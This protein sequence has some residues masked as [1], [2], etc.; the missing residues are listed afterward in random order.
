MSLLTRMFLVYMVVVL[1]VMVLGVGTFSYVS[2]GIEQNLRGNLAST[3]TRSS[4]LLDNLIKPMEYTSLHLLS[5]PRFFQAMEDL[6]SIERKGAANMVL[7]TL[8]QNE[9]YSQMMS[10]SYKKYF[11][12]ISAFNL[13]GDFFTSYYDFP[14]PGGSYKDA[15][16]DLPWLDTLREHDGR[17]VVLPPYWDPWNHEGLQRVF[18]V[19][20]A[21]RFAPDMGYIEVQQPYEELERVF[22][23]V[24]DPSQGISVCAF[25]REGGVLY[26]SGQSDELL[27]YYTSLQTSHTEPRQARNPLTGANEIFVNT[28]SEQT[29][30]TVLLVQDY[31]LLRQP[32]T[33]LGQQML[34][35]YLVLVGV[36]CAFFA[37]QSRNLVMPI[38]HLKSEMEATVL[39]SLPKGTRFESTNN[40]VT[41]L[42]HAFDDLKERLNELIRRELDLQNLQMQASFDALQAQVNP[43]FLYNILG[44]ISNRAAMMGDEETCRICGAIAGMLRYS[45]NTKTRLVTLKDEIEHLN[46]Y[47]YLMKERYEHRLEYTIEIDPAIL[48]AKLPKMVLQPLAENTL[49][50]AFEDREGLMRVSVTGTREKGQWRLVIEDNGS[51]FSREALDEIQRKMRAFD[52]D[53]ESMVRSG[54]ELGGLGIPNI[55]ARLR[56]F[57]PDAF[58]FAVENRK[59]GGARVVLGGSLNG[60]EDGA[61]TS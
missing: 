56:L 54:G 18:S 45:V 46:D 52:A 15:I 57:S 11:Y 30:V 39:E 3:A 25:T 7:I 36:S 12:R 44:L 27:N 35:M 5:N 38:R 58:L 20:R 34:L 47:I 49:T 21:I 8:A 42:G 51:G 37:L 23:A 53:R 1:A 24:A 16:R 48:A 4:Q 14:Q 17:V 50:H 6:A 31:R 32:L 28:Y 13:L 55:Y 29:G 2:H 19:S 43:H 40:E 22:A 9:I 60:K 10:Y 61:W 26:E 33:R 59:E 41:S